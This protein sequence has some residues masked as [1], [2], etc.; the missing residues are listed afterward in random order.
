DFMSIRRAAAARCGGLG[1]LVALGTLAQAVHAQELPTAQQ[2]AGEIKAGW[3]LGNSLEAQCG[4][5]AWGNPVVNPRLIDA[6]KAAGFNAIRIPAAWD[7]HAN[8]SNLIIDA[9]WLAR[10]KQVIDYA[11]DAHLYIILNIHWDGGW[12]QDH[13]VAALQSA[14]NH[15]QQAYWTQ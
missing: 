5:S 4:E 1:A 7:C 14:I 15:K 13:P 9:D 10:V 3:N 2:I 8:R 6:V 11:Y 12:L